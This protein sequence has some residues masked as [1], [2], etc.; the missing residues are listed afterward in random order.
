MKM[1]RHVALAFLLGLL[2]CGAANAQI[3]PFK[4]KGPRLDSSDLALMD[5][6]AEPLFQAENAT[7]GAS[8]T[9][10]NERTGASGVVTILDS[11]QSHGMLCRKVRYDFSV[12]G[13]RSDRSLTLDWCRTADGTWRFR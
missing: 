9:W 7:P 12:Q 8:A 1:H 4:G 11:T 2:I 6:A 10:N 13:R 5:K 3:N